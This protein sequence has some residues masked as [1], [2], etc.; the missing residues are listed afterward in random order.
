MKLSGL[1]EIHCI[2]KAK[3]PTPPLGCH[4]ASRR[5]ASASAG[6]KALPQQAHLLA[7]HKLGCAD[8][9]VGDLKRLDQRLWAGQDVQQ[10]CAL[11]C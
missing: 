10:V 3:T 5:A 7:G 1:A 11:L 4:S 2:T 9:Q 6:R 8:R